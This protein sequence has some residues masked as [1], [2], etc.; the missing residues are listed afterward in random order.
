[1]LLIYPSIEYEIN[2]QTRIFREAAGY[3]QEE[4][5]FL[6]GRDPSEVAACEDLASAESYSLYHLN[7]YARILGKVPADFVLEG[8]DED[9]IKINARKTVY[10]NKTVYRGERIY[11]DGRKEK[12]EPYEIIT[13]TKALNPSEE[14]RMLELFDGLLKAGYFQ[15]GKTGFEIHQH[16]L[17]CWSGPFRVQLLIDG[18][19]TLSSRRKR[20]KL[21]PMRQA[22]KTPEKWLLYKEDK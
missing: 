4:F 22:P 5:A 21:L 6:I 2:T 1:M 7:R 8:S 20:P 15:T 11:L 17:T 3:T 14:Q 16:V 12:L 18:L 13:K 9:V 10:P 19:S